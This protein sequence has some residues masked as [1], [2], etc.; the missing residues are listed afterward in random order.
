MGYHTVFKRK[1]YTAFAAISGMVAGGILLAT[2]GAYALEHGQKRWPQWYIGASAGF[3]WQDDT[4]VGSMGELSFDDGTGFAAALGYRPALNGDARGL[5]IELEYM[6]NRNDI[7]AMTAGG[8]PTLLSGDLTT[9]A[10]ML[11]LF[12]D[13]HNSSRF[14]PYLGLGGGW[15]G[16]ETVRQR[17]ERR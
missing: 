3:S 11:N 15:G 9:R 4:S 7:D 6:H 12:Y 14:T 5:R 10:G 13:F 2:Q 8:V 1:T 16:R 17:P